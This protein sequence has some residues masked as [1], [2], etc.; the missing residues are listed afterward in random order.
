MVGGVAISEGGG[1]RD[2]LDPRQ[3]ANQR[4]AMRIT[5]NEN[6]LNDDG[7]RVVSGRVLKDGQR[8]PA[9]APRAC[10]IAD[11][12]VIRPAADGKPRVLFEPP[13][14]KQDL[15]RLPILLNRFI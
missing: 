14:R 15:R 1:E 12:H 11:R 2:P 5:R 10:V 3:G 9:Y 13:I 7:A 6:A 8:S 4:F